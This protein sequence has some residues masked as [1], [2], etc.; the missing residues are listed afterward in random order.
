MKNKFALL[1]FIISVLSLVLMG[2]FLY[3]VYAPFVISEILLY[4]FLISGCIASVLAVI[5]G[6]I[7]IKRSKEN[8]KLAFAIIGTILGGLIILL[9]L[10]FLIQTV[11]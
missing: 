1:S 6:I 11:M 5:F 9:I 2:L 3:F 7:G 10:Y 4:L 8:G